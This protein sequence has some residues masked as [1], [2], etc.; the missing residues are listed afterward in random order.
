[1]RFAVAKMAEIKQIDE[2]EMKNQIG[3][4]AK[5]LFPKLR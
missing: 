5:R 3:E 2:T 1:V 4:N